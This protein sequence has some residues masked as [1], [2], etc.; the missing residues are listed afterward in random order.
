MDY[1]FKTTNFYGYE[2]GQFE[3][4][5][6]HYTITHTPNSDTYT[7]TIQNY[8]F[9]SSEDEVRNFIYYSPGDLIIESYDGYR[10]LFIPTAEKAAMRIQRSVRKYLKH[11]KWNRTGL[12]VMAVLAP[13]LYH[14][15]SPYMLRIFA[16]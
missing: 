4:L 7:A 14:P 9:I 15:K 12:A 1:F 11:L 16:R 6:G 13:I 8:T 2:R 10:S 3:L 5:L